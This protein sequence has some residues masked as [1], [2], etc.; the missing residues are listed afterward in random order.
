MS[1]RTS[2]LAAGL[3][4]LI[5]TVAAAGAD[6]LSVREWDVPTP[7]SFPHDPAV[8]IDGSLWYTGMAAN[9]LGR[10]D[11]STGRIREYRLKT[12]GSGPHGLTSDGIGHIWF[13]ANY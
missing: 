6:R 2:I 4:V 3:L 1:L 7:G 12:L 8:G 5:A 11:P 10:L 13:T 9:T